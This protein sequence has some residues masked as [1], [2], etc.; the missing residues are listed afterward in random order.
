MG[1]NASAMSD[2]Q[3]NLI[4]PHQH[5]QQLQHQQQPQQIQPVSKTIHEQAHPH[6]SAFVEKKSVVERPDMTREQPKDTQLTQ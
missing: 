5:Q 2:K 4:I 3:F 6:Q 1:P